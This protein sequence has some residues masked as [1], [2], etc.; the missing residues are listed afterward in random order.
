MQQTGVEYT[1]ESLMVNIGK[2]NILPEG[3]YKFIEYYC[4]DP[5]CDCN[6]GVFQMVELD[7]QGK[8]TQNT[9]AMIDYTWSKPVTAKNPTLASDF[10]GT[11]FA[12][13]G[14]EEFKKLLTNYSNMTA[15]LKNS[16]VK[17]REEHPHPEIQE[18]APIH[19]TTKVGRNDPCPCGS[20]KKYKRCCLQ[21]KSSQ[22]E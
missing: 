12:E 4:I 17:T 7:S 20:G 1:E 6:S 14:L 13:A 9:I 21:L 10:A 22:I 5:Q 8:E 15:K 11:G 16:Y 18:V 2:G 19:K 3:K